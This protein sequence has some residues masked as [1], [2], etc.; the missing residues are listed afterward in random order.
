MAVLH[1]CIPKYRS[2]PA[3]NDNRKCPKTKVMSRSP[4]NDSKIYALQPPQR[5]A[6]DFYKAHWHTSSKVN[7]PSFTQSVR[8]PS[9]LMYMET[10]LHAAMGRGNAIT[11]ALLIH[12]LPYL[13]RGRKERAFIE[14]LTANK[15]PLHNSNNSRRT[16]QARDW[17]T[18]AKHVH[19]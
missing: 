18:I 2:F 11:A 7:I 5:Q 6:I 12:D 9:A 1:T 17:F 14:I 13:K 10:F 15:Y 3:K 16:K 4:A 8:S 19:G